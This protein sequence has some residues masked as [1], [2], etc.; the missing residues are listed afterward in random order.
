MDFARPLQVYY[1]RKVPP[2]TSEHVQS[3][4][5][6]PQDVEVID[7]SNSHTHDYDVPIALRKA[8]SQLSSQFATPLKSDL[9]SEDYVSRTLKIPLSVAQDNR[10]KRIQIIF[11]QR[12]GQHRK[13]IDDIT[14][15]IS[16]LLGAS[17]TKD[18]HI[19]SSQGITLS[20]LDFSVDNCVINSRTTRALQDISNQLAQPSQSSLPNLAISSAV[21]NDGQSGT[22]TDTDP[23]FN[24]DAV[25]SIHELKKEG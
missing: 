8:I 12:H 24:N 13:K 21:A 25:D 5:S 22:F 3:S 4:S 19:A 20:R 6:E 10:K 2:P 18:K 23:S 17:S 16:R 7:S 14:T 1:R 11:E 15:Q 9:S